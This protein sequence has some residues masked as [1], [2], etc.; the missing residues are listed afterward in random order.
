MNEKF[1]SRLVASKATAVEINKQGQV[2]FI[3]SSLHN[4]TEWIDS[5][6]RPPGVVCGDLLDIYYDWTPSR[7]YYVAR[8][9]EETKGE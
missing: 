3:H 6:Y 4:G 8:V 9:P 7:G 1:G 5:G 2:R